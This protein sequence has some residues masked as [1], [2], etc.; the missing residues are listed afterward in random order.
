METNRLLG[1]IYWSVLN[2]ILGLCFS[3]EA[4][5]NVV[6]WFTR[7]KGILNSLSSA[8]NSAPTVTEDLGLYRRVLHIVA[9]DGSQEHCQVTNGRR[10]KRER[11]KVG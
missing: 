4:N 11:E 8:A 2:R 5:R 9:E 1:Y 7:F 3:L 10:N 6:P